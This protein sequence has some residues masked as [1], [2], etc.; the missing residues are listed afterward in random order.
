MG[1]QEILMATEP[2][3][4]WVHKWEQAGY[5]KA[6][7]RVVGFEEKFYR[8]HPDAPKQAGGTCDICGQGIMNIFTVKSADNHEFKTGED[9]VQHTKDTALIAEAKA[10]R[11]QW[12]SPEQKERE[13]S[14]RSEK[15]RAKREEQEARV[16]KFAQEYEQVI[17][18]AS[19]VLGAPHVPQELRTLAEEVLEGLVTGKWYHGP[20]DF[21]IRD[22]ESAAE[23]AKL[24]TWPTKNEWMGVAGDKFENLPVL[25]LG[26]PRFQTQFG[27]QMINKFR[28]V[29]GPD[30]GKLLVW[31]TSGGFPSSK[32]QLMSINGTVKGHDTYGDEL[33]TQ[34][35]RVS[36]YEE[37]ADD[38]T[39]PP[40]TKLLYQQSG[41]NW[42]V[43]A[44]VEGITPK[45]KIRIKVRIAK[46]SP[47]S[48]ELVA[49]WTLSEPGPND[50]LKKWDDLDKPDFV[51]GDKVRYG[52]PG[53]FKEFLPAVV[54]E[55][56][57]SGKVKIRYLEKGE[58]KKAA[59]DVYK[60]HR[61]E[62]YENMAE[63]EGL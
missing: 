24:P 35:T 4:P 46:E 26:G 29:E 7:F 52:R 10:T 33:Q 28:V 63:W 60:V 58:V 5:G 34:L 51:P 39:F 47:V 16:I 32:W 55:V 20:Q 31:F 19:A 54:V 2:K 18:N 15:E 41:A 27:W 21:Q 30:A 61:P 14:W 50:D 17:R 45:G 42:K 62:P 23:I 6:P 12:K 49:A 22:L 56:T 57:K 36:E 13:K 53:Y 48:R 9:C 37:P 44:V 25:N 1:S 3:K 38:E 11:R 59:V 40:G 8:A 43:P